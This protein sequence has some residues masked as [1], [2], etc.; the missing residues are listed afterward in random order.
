MRTIYRSMEFEVFYNSLSVNV[1]E[2]IKYALNV[3][4][5]IR[6]VNVK[7]VKKLIN[8]EFYELRVSVDNEYRIVIFAIDNDNFAESEQIVLLN[9]F[10]KKSTKDYKREIN[11][12]RRILKSLSYDDKN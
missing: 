9:G 7:L 5:E 8:T 10:V 12:A 4:T 6:I 3:I 11:K 1:K 2:K